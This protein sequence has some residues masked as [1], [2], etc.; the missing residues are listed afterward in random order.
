[1][2]DLAD[3]PLEKNNLA[4]PGYVRSPTEQHHYERLREQLAITK[5]TRLQPLA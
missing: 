2:Y 5:R 1:M 3:D 4:R